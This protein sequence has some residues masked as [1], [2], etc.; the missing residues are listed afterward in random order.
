MIK[1]RA[2]KVKL[3]L[4][5]LSQNGEENHHRTSINL[6]NGNCAE[7][8]QGPVSKGIRVFRRP[9]R[10]GG[11]YR[12]RT[13]INTCMTMAHRSAARIMLSRQSLVT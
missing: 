12:Y 9:S 3:Y 8:G 11:E 13:T 2:A 7:C 1:P 5:I 6:G 4:F 10:H